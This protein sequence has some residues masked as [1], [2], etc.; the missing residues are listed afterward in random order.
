MTTSD[1]RLGW[2]AAAV[3][4]ALLAVAGA[5]FV[6]CANTPCQGAAPISITTHVDGTTTAVCR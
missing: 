3:F 4:V 6:S 1:H 5:G 2:P